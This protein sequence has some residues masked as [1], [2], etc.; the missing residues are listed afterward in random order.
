MRLKSTLLLGLA[1][2]APAGLRAQPAPLQGTYAFVAAESDDVGRAIQRA[3]AEMNFVTRPIARGRLRR[4]NVPYGTITLAQTTSQV[5]VTSDERAPIVTPADGTPIRWT[6]EDGEVF[7]VHTRWLDGSLEQTFA[8]EDGQ[9]INLFSLSPDGRTLTM[10]VTVT[11]PRLPEP[12]V[13][14]LRYR[15]Q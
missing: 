9:R 11:S 1:L 3:T 10:R 14:S 7:D 2:L 5:T 12:M 15:R 6:R 13:Y 8:A 4:T